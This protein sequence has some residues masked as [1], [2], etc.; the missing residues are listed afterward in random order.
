ML[1]GEL[2]TFLGTN[3]WYGMHL[4]SE[5]TGDRSRLLEELDHL[6]ALGI[7]NLRIMAC[8]EGSQTAPWQVQP[9][10]QPTPGQYQ[11]HLLQGLDF[12]L[13]EM[14]KRDMKAVVCLN[15]FWPWSGGMATYVQWVSG[16]EI[17]YPPP[18]EGGSWLRYMLYTSKFYSNEV[19]K[20]LFSDH[21]RAI[22]MRTN[23]LTGIAYRNDPVIMA[24][25]LANEPRAIVRP[26]AYRK[27]IDE[28]S[29]LIRSL[30]T[31]HLISVGSEGATPSRWSGN[32]FRRDHAFK[33]IDY[34]TVHIWLENWG[35]YDPTD[36]TTYQSGLAQATD[37]LHHHVDEAAALGKPLVLEEFG[38][39][40]DQR[41]YGSDSPTRQRD[42]FLQFMFKQ[43]FDL[44]QDDKLSGCNFWAWGGKGR[45]A[46]PGAIWQPGEDLIGDP[47]HELQGWYS[48]YDTD[49]ST[50]EIIRNWSGRIG[51]RHH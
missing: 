19:A 13:M 14:A 4:G 12:L 48:V 17:P 51:S 45:P 44:I 33:N 31:R 9:A 49:T 8:S 22:V 34:M 15:N 23:S 3:F 28:T 18:A 7:K 38:I 10:L 42:S 50:L 5:V 37:Y 21:V 1:G 32:R 27:W 41:A 2:Y 6:S 24:W 11:P 47:P 39:A 16:Q 43:T 46:S 26:R 35:W 36:E 30:D 20:S 29:S 25:Q 40:R